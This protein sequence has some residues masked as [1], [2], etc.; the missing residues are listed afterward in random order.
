M[1]NRASELVLEQV[2]GMRL[3]LSLGHT[4]LLLCVILKTLQKLIS[5]LVSNAY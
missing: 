4:F 2:V 1:E 3:W 5:I